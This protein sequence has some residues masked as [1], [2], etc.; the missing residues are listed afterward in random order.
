MTGKPIERPRR[1]QRRTGQR[2][3]EAHGE[4]WGHLQNFG[5][6]VSVTS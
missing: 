6:Q 3:G 1:G 5:D 4:N 2:G